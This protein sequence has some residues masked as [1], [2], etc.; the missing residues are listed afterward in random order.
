MFRRRVAPAAYGE[1]NRTG[2]T[3]PAFFGQIC[4][5]CTPT[6]SGKLAGTCMIKTKPRL[7]IL[8]AGPIGLE[9]A[10]LARQLSWAVT[11]YERG[12]VGENLERWGFVRLFSPFGLNCTA[13]GKAIIQAEHP[14]HRLPGEG[15][16]LTGR[17]HVVAYLTPLATT[18]LIGD[19]IKNDSTVVAIGRVG[20]FKTDNDNR[21]ATP[22]RMLLRDSK[23][24]ETSAEADIVLDCSGVY[25]QHRLV[26]DGGL[27]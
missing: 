27:P 15:D 16:L 26:G 20:V 23:G 21:S 22:F 10:L 17:E 14:S 19:C 18:T 2:P 25:G 24:N 13:L 7:A 9:A 3:G 5:C 12:R 4:G 1:C 8:G 6:A 11:I